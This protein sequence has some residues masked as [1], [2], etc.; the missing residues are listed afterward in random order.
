MY[1]P[2]PSPYNPHTCETF[3]IPTDNDL[4]ISTN[5]N[6]T[7][8]KT[9][10]YT[11]KNYFTNLVSI[12]DVH[13][14][15]SSKETIKQVS[16]HEDNTEIDISLSNVINNNSDTLKAGTEISAFD[17][18][19]SLK[20]KYPLKFFLGHLN[21]NSIPH[22]FDSIMEIVKNHLDIFL[23]SETKIDKTFID[24]QFYCEGFSKPYRKDRILGGGGLLLYINEDI[25][26]AQKLGHPNPDDSEIMCVEINLRKQKWLIIGIYRPPSKNLNNFLNHLSRITDFYS[27]KYDRMI[28]MGDFNAEPTNEHVQNFCD[29]FKLFNLVKEN[30]CFKGPPKCYDL[31]LTNM[32]HNFMN[33]KAI[34]TGLSDCHKMTISMMKTEIIKSQPMQLKYR[35][36]T[37]FQP[38]LFNCELKTLLDDKFNSTSEF[39]DFHRI[40][41]EL[42]DKHAPNKKKY[43]RANN[44]PFMTKPLRKLIMERSRYQNAYFNNKTVEN[45]DKYRIARN[46]CVKM[47]KKAKKDYFANL[48]INIVTDNKKFWKAIKPIFSDKSCFKSKITL[49]ENN[50]I[51]SDDNLIANI[52]NEYFV[53]ITKDL[54]IKT[55]DI[56]EIPEDLITEIDHIDKIIY[57]YNN[58]PSILKINDIV[59]V[60][61]PFSFEK[62]DESNFEKEILELNSKKAPGCDNIPTK[63]LKES[64]NVIKTPLTL[65][66]NKSL[67]DG[68]FPSD[69]KYADVIPFFKKDNKTEKENYRPISILPS[70]SKV[71]ERQIF[72]QMSRY[73]DDILSPYLC[74]FRKGFN[75]QHVLLR[76][77]N[78]L[79]KSL[80][81]KEKVGLFLL[82]LSKA[83]DC[84]PHDL[85]IAKLNAYNFDKQ[86]LRLIY[87]YL[88]GRKQRVKINT[89][90]SSWRDILSGVPQG[91]V[92]GPLLFNI[93]INDLLYFIE[94]SDIYNFADDNTLTVAD[95]NLETI[96]NKLQRDIDYLKNWFT[97]NG[98]LLNEKKCQFMVAE[99][100]NFRINTESI[101]V[102]NKSVD[103]VKSVK[104]L[105]V[106]LDKN[107]KMTEHIQKLCKKAGAKLSALARIAPFIDEHKR[108]LLMKS[109]ILSQFNYCPLVWMYCQRRSNHL[110]NRIHERALRI[111]YNDYT[112][113]FESLLER[114]HTVTIHQKN[115]QSLSLEIYKTVNN[116]NPIV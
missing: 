22:K 98:M 65:L 25:P 115:I 68:T 40:F 59:N 19:K 81:K 8:N 46:I 21:I 72:K 66:F 89:E 43:I 44:S 5:N 6:Y 42:L 16:A 2:L 4:S 99:T 76:L 12:T 38:H 58:H 41:Y 26:S 73:V 83:F 47:T 9:S 97:D 86:S 17:D 102:D 63:V 62:A 85:L 110:I 113:S 49:I 80:D 34:T 88:N 67:D 107:I 71:F 109:F 60:S 108:I 103:E 111:A 51:I 52:L 18:L 82:D 84:I 92:L 56:E 114:D 37:H 28:I 61:I 33:T 91:S 54:N 20:L 75:T 64:I 15:H 55:Y 50:E 53:N 96:I 77:K 45:W 36:Y 35:D 104:L 1:N 106:T 90:Y 116:L 39:S 30:T 100:S 70:I 57:N 32:K 79:N 95:V 69:L 7:N 3:Y 24:T 87:S 94:N 101:I 13:S 23:I 10:I 74:G 14:E 105:G 11:T 48:D 31:I 29:S 78:Q 93:F 112:S 27:S